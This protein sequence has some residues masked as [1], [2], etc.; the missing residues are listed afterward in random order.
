MDHDDE[1]SRLRRAAREIFDQALRDS[2]AY[3]AVR[4]ALR[5]DG[6]RLFAQDAHFDLG[7]SARVYSVALGKAARTM[8]AALDDVLG[9]RLVRGVASAPGVGPTLP[10]RWSVYAGGHPL[11]DEQ[12]VAAARAAFDLLREADREGAL[13]VFLVS[14]GGSAMMEC[15]GDPSVSLE[16]LRAAGSALVS[17]G[18]SIAEINCVRRALS[19]VKGGGL[20]ARAPRASQLTLIVSDVNVGREADV[21]SGPTFPPA[22][23]PE[24]ARRVVEKYGLAARLPAPVLRA[25]ERPPRTRED[26]EAERGATRVSLTLLDNA[27]A[28]ESAARAARS[29]G[30][31][32]GVATDLVEQDVA[33]GSVALVERVRELRARVAAGAACLISGGEFACPVRGEGVGGRS[34]ETALRCAFDFDR[35]NAAREGVTSPRH[36]VALAAGTDGIDGNSPAAGALADHTTLARARTHGLDPRRHLDDSDAHTFFQALGDAI[37]TG[38]TGTNVRD[39][40][41]LLAT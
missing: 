22:D 19:A 4:R 27:R 29:R 18:A 3:T 20:S 35:L 1:L 31:S 36:L 12:S 6:P 23:G 10:D 40:R 17:C 34:A 32:V 38:P 15:A 5:V 11:P 14:G 16:E 30:F 8:A 21:A 7:R 28:L 26:A 13:V 2:D 37:V 41:I 39:L 24:D 9:P 25:L 33:E